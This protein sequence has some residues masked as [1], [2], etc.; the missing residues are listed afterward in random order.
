MYVIVIYDVSVERV[1]DVRKFLKQRMDWV[2]NSSFE[3][4]LSEGQIV[5]MR[6]GLHE[7]IDLKSDSVIIFTVAYKGA[8]SKEVLGIEKNVPTNVI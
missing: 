6:M 3:G 8:L 2:Q 5:E 4:E 1:N 7:I